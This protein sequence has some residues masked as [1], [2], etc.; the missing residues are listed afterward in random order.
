MEITPIGWP[1]LFAGP[2][3]A[4]WRPK[5]LYV[6]TL[7]LLPFTATAVINVGS[8]ETASGLQA[9]IYLGTWL[10]LRYCGS[11]LWRL[12]FPLPQRGRAAVFWLGIFM[13]I[14][15]LSLI[16]PI[17]LAGIVHV[18][19]DVPGD[20]STKT[21][22]LRGTNISGVIYMLFGYA[23]VYLVATVNQTA[24][25]MRLTLRSFLAGCSFA[26]C[27]AY[28]ELFCKL[29][30]V[31]YP[32][33]IF[34]T[35][36]SPA[37]RGFDYTDKLGFFY[38]LSSVSVEPSILSQTLLIAVA[39]FL[40]FVFGRFH[41]FGR[42]TDRRLFAVTFLT[43]CL[44]TS[45]TGYVGLVVLALTTILL[46]FLKGRLKP[47]LA[48]Q[49]VGIFLLGYALYITVPTVHQLIYEQVFA[50]QTTYSALQRTI[51]VINGYDMFRLHPLLGIG[52]GSVTSHDLIMNILG[53]CGVFG[54]LSF[55]IS[56]YYA[57][58]SLYRALPAKHA[59][60]RLADLIQL[61]FA[62][63]LALAATM[64]TSILAGIPY[65][66]PFFWL[67]CGLAMIGSPVEEQASA[68]T[69]PAA[70]SPGL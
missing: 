33:F 64:A 9:S 35:S 14:V 62:L 17:R 66:F 65:V 30:G 63:Y 12:R 22:T 24:T 46:L 2:M 51:T 44:T 39:L 7:F 25:I 5:W 45:S 28:I 69:I 8:G 1:L 59:I 55:T 16:Q 4:L 26:A 23:I 57:F 36:A 18:P 56:I 21:L 3:L 38:R 6:L 20:I 10:L 15:V 49:G 32:Y 54:L 41:L 19:T 29:T 58:Q 48:L 11:A 50:K 31:Q 53:N 37:A 52:W 27:W 13:G 47:K 34:N 40:P 60:R 68:T 61:D 42:K 70:G 43:L 67:I